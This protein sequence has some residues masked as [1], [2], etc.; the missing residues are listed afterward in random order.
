[1]PILALIGITPDG[2]REVVAFTV[3]EREREGA[4]EDLLADIK[5]R[6]VQTGDLWITDR[7]QAM[8]NAS[9]REFPSSAR[10]RCLKHKMRAVA[11]CCSTR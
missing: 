8:L 4:W 6:G 1:M 10:Q 7:H 2:Q 5:E 11:C 3:G 9:T